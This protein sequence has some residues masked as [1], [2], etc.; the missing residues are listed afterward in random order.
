MILFSSL[1]QESY[2]RKLVRVDTLN[3]GK[4]YQQDKILSDLVHLEIII[5]TIPKH[6][7]SRIRTKQVT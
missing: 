7:S 5:T 3:V 1:I 6:S 4:P 2:T